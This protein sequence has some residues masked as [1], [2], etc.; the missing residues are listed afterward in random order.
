M[1]RR[2]GQPAD[3]AIG[4]VLLVPENIDAHL[5]RIRLDG[6]DYRLAYPAEAAE[7]KAMF[8]YFSRF[9]RKRQ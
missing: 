9:V 2:P 8:Q 3:D 5:Q 1:L 4:G 6:Y 7:A